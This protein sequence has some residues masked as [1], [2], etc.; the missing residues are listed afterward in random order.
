MKRRFVINA[1][2]TSPA[3]QDQ[4]TRLLENNGL[5]YWHW[6]GNAWLATSSGDIWSAASLRNKILETAEGCQCIVI[7]IAGPSAWAAFG[8]P[9]NLEWLKQEWSE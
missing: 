9:S 3:Q 2:N 5:K 4:I 6:F 8:I 7:E 1:H